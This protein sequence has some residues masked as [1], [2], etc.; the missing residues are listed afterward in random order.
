[1]SPVGNQPP[2]GRDH[3]AALRVPVAAEDLAAAEQDLAVGRDTDL[4][5]GHRPTDR[6]QAGFE[7][8]GD[9]GGA[10]GLGE[11]VPLVDLHAGARVEGREAA[12]E[13][14]AAGDEV[15]DPA[16]HGVADA[17][18]DELVVEGT[19][20]L[21]CGA[22]AGSP[23]RRGGPPSPRRSG[24]RHSPRGRRRKHGRRTPPWPARCCRSSPACR[25]CRGGRS[26]GTWP[27]RPGGLPRPGPGRGPGGPG[28][29]CRR[30]P[31]CGRRRA[32]WGGRGGWP[33][34]PSTSI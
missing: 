25:G 29:G 18:V 28:P 26:G 34:P 12:A 2:V 9:R 22:R 13:R 6:A 32:T 21:Q 1:M 20:R 5:A 3:P 24:R 7:G 4:R 19:G 27:G 33:G 10:G 16:A 14:G 17:A 15:A 23:C 11:A 8:W 31:P 30:S